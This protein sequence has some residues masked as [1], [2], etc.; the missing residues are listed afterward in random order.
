SVKSKCAHPENVKI[1]QIDLE[2][3]HELFEKSKV[4]IKLFGHIDILVNNAGI[5]QR[6][7]TTDTKLEVDQRLMNTNYIGT[8]ALSKFILP[9]MLQ[10][11]AGQIV[12]VTSMAGK[13]GTPLRSTYAATKHALHG[14]MDSLVLAY[15]YDHSG[16]VGFTESYIAQK[17]LGAEDKKGFRHPLVDT[18]SRTGEVITDFEAHYS[19]WEFN[20]TS[21][22]LFF[23]PSTDQQRYFKR[24][25]R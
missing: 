14:F 19:A 22:A 17:F 4:A 16:D 10:M 1:L 15:C 11:G 7:L 2:N 18:M 5:S 24:P 8:V 9:Q 23:L 3:T 21:N 25:Q 12:T 6:S 13:Y 20:N